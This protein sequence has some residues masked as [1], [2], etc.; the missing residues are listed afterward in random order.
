[1]PLLDHFHPPLSVN[2]HWDAFHSR[3]AVAIADALNGRLPED[4]FAEPQTS[5]GSRI[6]VDVATFDGGS[7][8]ARGEAETGGGTTVLTAPTRAYSPPA[9]AASMP[10][11]FPDSFEVRV[12]SREAGPTL[13][14]AIELVSPGNKDRE[15]FRRAFASKCASYLQQDVG[16]MVVE[17]VTS[18]RAN[19][20]NELADL[21]GLG[22]KFHL[23]LDGLY[24]VAYHPVRYRASGPLSTF[25]AAG[26]V[27]RID[28]W[29]ESLAVHQPLPTLPLPLDKDQFVP[30][31]LEA[32][33][34]EARQ[35]SRL[36]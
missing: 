5:A 13:V 23:P 7:P 21:L 4:Y 30:L 29:Q 1:M 9:P 36:G 35:R 8:A 34:S 11:I 22:E 31:D 33:Y 14:A 3:W 25:G 28:M 27:G 15:E 19:L 17:I 20:H 10:A 6:E 16:L 32:A 24:A 26:E 18:R 2:R 12:I